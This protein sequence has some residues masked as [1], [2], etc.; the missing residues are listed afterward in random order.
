MDN[1]YIELQTQLAFQDDAIQELNMTVARQQLEI[2]G[3]KRNM[4]ELQ[5]QIR[6]LTSPQVAA[7]AEE[8][9]PPHY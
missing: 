5:R 1:D 3:L 9:P 8:T 2:D 6:T 4:D 7:A